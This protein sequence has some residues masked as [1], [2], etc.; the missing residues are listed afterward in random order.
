MKELIKKKILIHLHLYYHNQIDFM[1]KMLKSVVDCEWDLYVTITEDNELSKNKILKLKHNAHIIKVTNRG[2]DVLPFIKVLRAVDISKYDYVLKIHTKNYCIPTDF[3]NFYAKGYDWRNVL[4]MSLLGSKRIF[5]RNL[6]ILSNP[7]NG[8]IVNR[9]FFLQF[10]KYGEHID[11]NETNLLNDLKQKLN[12]HSNY[13]WFIAGTMFFSKADIFKQII[14]SD[15]NDSDFTIESKTGVNNSLAHTLERIFCILADE[16]GYK[17]I[18]IKSPRKI[19]YKK[20]FSITNE[21]IHKVINIFGFKLKIKSN[22]LIEKQYKKLL[23]QYN[24]L[25][26]EYNQY[27]QSQII[28][29]QEADKKRE[30]L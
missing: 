30:S 11:P 24:Q 15:I 27:K 16:A 23:E 4:I 19:N 29:K 12:I 8:M 14:E 25:S 1:I 10:G 3:N 13:D 21:N 26:Y 9:H 17:I 18:S 22:K 7:K 20:I 28:D 6:S 2:Y 5:K